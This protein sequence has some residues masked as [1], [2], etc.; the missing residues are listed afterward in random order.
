MAGVCVF[1]GAF[2]P[3][4]LSHRRVVETAL[5]GLQPS[6]LLVVPCGDRHALKDPPLAP[7]GGSARDVRARVRRPRPARH[8]R[9][10]RDRPR[11]TVV[12]IDTVRSLRA[13]LGLEDPLFLLVGA[14][15][16]ASLDRWHEH[17]SLF[18]LATIVVFPRKGCRVDERALA[19]LD[20]RRKH[21]DELLAHV[22]DM[23]ADDISSSEIRARLGRGDPCTDVLD[24]RVLG[25][26]RSHGLYPAR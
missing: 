8:R 12:T 2:D 19:R 6:S 17:H 10:S 4:H 1:G 25:H 13:E 7:A 21:K 23:P 22:L 11:G 16:V 9:P 15:N 14:D 3:P 26:I 18:E 20:L 5:A 24:P